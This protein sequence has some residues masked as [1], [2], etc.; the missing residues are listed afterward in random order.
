MKGLGV[1][2]L[3]PLSAVG[4]TLTELGSNSPDSGVTCQAP[5]GTDAGV[6]T[7]VGPEAFTLAS[8][9]QTLQR[10][11]D[12]QERLSIALYATPTRCEQ[13]QVRSTD[14]GLTQG[15]W[16]LGDVTID[17]YSAPGGSV[18]LGTV[19]LGS[20]DGGAHALVTVLGRAP[21]E[22]GG[23]GWTGWTSVSGS[24]RL[25]AIQ[26]CSVLG[27]FDATLVQGD[28]GTTAMTGQFAAPFCPTRR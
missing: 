12:S 9:Y 3:I 4:C 28:G 10:F 14:G 2:L 6:A 13:V 21:T 22:D 5:S 7:L 17:V 16:R 27:A 18:G 8:G 15:A 26:T 19:P 20:S 1:A 11:N 23:T 24:V 25:D